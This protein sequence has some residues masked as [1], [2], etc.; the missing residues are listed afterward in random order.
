MGCPWGSRVRGVPDGRRR[1]FPQR[2]KADGHWLEGSWMEVRAV[3]RQKDRG[4][5]EFRDVWSWGVGRAQ[6]RRLRS[7]KIVYL[8][9][10]GSMGGDDAWF[11]SLVYLK[12][13]GKK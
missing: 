4:L 7:V 8:C 12:N 13:S 5:S 10:S 6:S 11:R 3:L 2:L 9:I 1:P